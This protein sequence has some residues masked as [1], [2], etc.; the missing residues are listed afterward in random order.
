MLL[1]E[2]VKVQTHLILVKPEEAVV[3]EV[4]EVLVVMETYLL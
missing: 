3:A 4:M 2:A 1:Q